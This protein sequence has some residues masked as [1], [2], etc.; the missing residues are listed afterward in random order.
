M[1]ATPGTGGTW[2]TPDMIPLLGSAAGPYRQRASGHLISA[3]GLAHRV[4]PSVLVVGE[5]LVTDAETPT[6]DKLFCEA[7]G[8]SEARSKVMVGGV[9][10]KVQRVA[11]NS[12]KHQGVGRGII[13]GIAAGMSRCRRQIELPPQPE[14]QG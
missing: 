7:I 13:I 5:R 9:T 11:A 6:Q 12:C 14:I 4:I 3:I 10:G 1:H 2:H 8:Q